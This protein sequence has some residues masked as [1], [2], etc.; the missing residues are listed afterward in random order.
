MTFQTH[1][2]KLEVAIVGRRMEWL[3]SGERTPNCL[4]S[5]TIGGAVVTTIQRHFNRC[6]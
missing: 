5:L 2:R 1:V 6:C 4:H 3:A